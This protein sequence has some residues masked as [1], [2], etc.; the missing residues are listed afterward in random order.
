MAPR[1]AELCQRHRHHLTM[2]RRAHSFVD[3]KDPAIFAN[4][5]GPAGR[6]GLI[7]INNAVGERHVLRRITQDGIIEAERLGK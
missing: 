5:E 4:V 3:S 6:K 1:D 7:S 2:R